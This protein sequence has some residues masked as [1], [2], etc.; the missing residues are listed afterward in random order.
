MKAKWRGLY[1]KLG[2][3][4]LPR[5][6]LRRL[7]ADL[8]GMMHRLTRKISVII[9][10]HRKKSAETIPAHARVGRNISVVT[11]R[12]NV[13]L[14]SGGDEI[15]STSVRT[16]IA[17]ENREQQPKF[18]PEYSFLENPEILD[19]QRL[20][21]ET[22]GANNEN[23][24]GDKLSAFQELWEELLGK[25]TGEAGVD[26]SHLK[27]LFQFF[28]Y[29]MRILDKGG[30]LLGRSR[31]GIFMSSENEKLANRFDNFIEE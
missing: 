7:N 26:E 21:D 20:F 25:Y 10:V 9:S 29:N 28:R 24:R 15:L 5:A 6:D 11:E 12:D 17:M 30:M 27:Q 2:S 14:R 16:Y 22:V 8:R 31:I 23:T 13:K 19:L 18:N 1:S 4:P 3:L